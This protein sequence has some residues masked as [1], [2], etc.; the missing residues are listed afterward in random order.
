MD[1]LQKNRD[2]SLDI[3]KI[4]AIFMVCSYHFS[5]NKYGFAH[6]NSFT[7]ESLIST[8]L[9]MINSIC[10]PLFFLVNGALLLTRPINI[11][12]HIKKSLILIICHIV[13][14]FITILIIGLYSEYNFSALGFKDWVNATILLGSLPG[15]DLAHFWFIPMLISIYIISPFISKMFFSGENNK[16][17]LIAFIAVLLGFMLINGDFVI[18]QK[19]LFG[20]TFTNFESLNKLNPFGSA[21]IGYIFYFLLGGILYTFKEKLLKVK[22]YWLCLAYIVGFSLLFCYWHF[23]NITWDYIFGAYN[24]IPTAVMATSIFLL[25]IKVP[26]NKIH[27][28]KPL[29]FLIKTIGSNTLT[30]YYTHWILGYT[31]LRIFL[32][33]ISYGPLSNI[34]KALIFVI[35]GSLIGFVIKKIPILKHLAQ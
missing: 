13:F 16:T 33:Y 28:C 30:I 27:Q 19:C 14:R 26:N 20:K 12:K 10:I 6:I 17:F 11:K 22:W 23:Q 21:R 35:V 34:I 32:P 9:F 5:L 7:F 4:L 3:L 24:L 25:C 8:I 15:I 1:T 29:A 2:Y 18:L 31:I